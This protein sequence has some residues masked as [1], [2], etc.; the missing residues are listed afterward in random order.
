MYRLIFAAFTAIFLYGCGGSDDGPDVE[1]IQLDVSETS[2]A[3]G[4]TTEIQA[5]IGFY[6]DFTDTSIK[7]HNVPIRSVHDQTK[8]IQY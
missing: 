3:V 7:R 4:D 6:P 1:S 5:S 2:I 8:K